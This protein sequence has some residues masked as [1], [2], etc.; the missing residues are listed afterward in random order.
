MPSHHLAAWMLNQLYLALPNPDK[1]W[2]SECQTVNFHT[3]LWEAQLLACFREQGLLV[4]QPYE[5][6]D[7]RIENRRGGVAWVEA[8]TANPAVPYNHVNAPP[9][10]I[11]ATREELF[12]GPAALRF[13]K[14]LGNKIARN[15]TQLPHVAGNPFAIALADFQAP[16]S[17]VWSREGLI[18]Y[19]YGEGA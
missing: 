9:S 14:T 19:L 3:R 15:Y 5:S 11:P 16:A 8:V 1:H 7:F 12:F 4:A 13:A 6:P 2:A 10:A 18:G 17:M